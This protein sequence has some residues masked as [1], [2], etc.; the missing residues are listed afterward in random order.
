MMKIYTVDAF[1]DKAFKGNPAGVCPM[2]TML[3]ENTLQD[4]AREMNLSETAFFLPINTGYQLRWFTPLKEVDLCG[5]ATLATAH[6]LWQEGFLAKNQLAVFSALSGE[7]HAQK[8]GDWIEMQFPRGTVPQMCQPKSDL[9]QALGIEKM[10]FMGEYRPNRYLIEVTKASQVRQ[11]SP[12]F[13]KLHEIGVD[14]IIVT[15]HSDD[16]AFDFVSRYFAPGAGINEDPVTGSA[17][18]Y[19]TPYWAAK[20]G[21]EKLNAYQ[22]SARGGILQLQLTPEH[23]MIRGQAVTVIKGEMMLTHRVSAR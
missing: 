6:I 9:L 8:Q 20:L 11:L 19:L 1:T 13:S 10:E 2:E 16:A 18:C 23:V 14:R 7:L 4:I 15:A 5:H 17:H 3:P 12:N 22:V 21:K